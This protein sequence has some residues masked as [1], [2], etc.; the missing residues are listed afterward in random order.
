MKTPADSPL[1]RSEKFTHLADLCPAI[2]SA[3][4]THTKSSEDIFVAYRNC[5]SLEC[6][7]CHTVVSGEELYLLGQP[8][9]GAETT[10]DRRRLRLGFCPNVHCK[11]FDCFITFKPDPAHDWAAHLHRADRLVRDLEDFR[12]G[13]GKHWRTALIRPALIA[14]FGLMVIFLAHQL[15][16]GGRI[17]WLREPEKFQVD[18]DPESEPH[19]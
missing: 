10:T 8:A 2:T 3:L 7:E 5:V 17:P 11:S 9:E 15:Y 14:A 12:A 18:I 1:L 19:P 16:F 6:S 13:R 4:K